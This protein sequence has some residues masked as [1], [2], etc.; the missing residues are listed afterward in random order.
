MI[1]NVCAPNRVVF[2]CVPQGRG[3][4]QLVEGNAGLFLHRSRVGLVLL[5]DADG[6]HIDEVVFGRRVGCDCLQIIRLDAPAVPV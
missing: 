4:Q 5:A 1:H 3:S 6:I 2:F